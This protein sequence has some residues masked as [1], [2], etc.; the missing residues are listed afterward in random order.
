LPGDH[1]DA[2]FT[3][4]LEGGTAPVF[5]GFGSMAIL[6]GEELLD[7]VGVVCEDLEIRG[8][9][10]AGWTDL[11]GPDCDLPEGVAI[12]DACDY[13]WLF[14][15]CAAVM[16]HGGSGT[17]HTASRAGAPQIV[18]SLFA[19]Q[20]FW[21]KRVARTGA[22]IHLPFQRLSEDSLKEAVLTALSEQKAEAAAALGAAMQA[23]DGL[24][25][26]CQALESGSK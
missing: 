5:F 8:V 14:P 19:D 2:G 23:E 11:H 4:W 6:S 26:A 9:I 20:P 13:A 18:C 1:K 25:A 15:Q 12:A 16:H 17:T 10:G 22:G 21:A 24:A 3:Q 7:L